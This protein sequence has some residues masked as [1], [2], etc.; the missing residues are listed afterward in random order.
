MKNSKIL[1]KIM[2]KKKNPKQEATLF[3][4]LSKTLGKYI[5]LIKVKLINK[6]LAQT[7]KKDCC[8]TE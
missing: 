7:V 8:I 1:E 5:R 4:L 6:I 2:T 3:E